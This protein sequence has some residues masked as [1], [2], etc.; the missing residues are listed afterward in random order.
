ML[1]LNPS[2]TRNRRSVLGKNSGVVDWQIIEDV[3]SLEDE[4]C[5]DL[6]SISGVFEIDLESY[7]CVLHFKIKDKKYVSRM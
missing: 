4:V 7:S 5:F 6:V 1:Y 2:L 3:D